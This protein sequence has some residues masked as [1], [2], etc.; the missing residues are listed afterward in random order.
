MTTKFYRAICEA[1]LAVSS[2]D[3]SSCYSISQNGNIQQCY[4]KT[5]YDGEYSREKNSFEEICS[6]SNAETLTPDICNSMKIRFTESANQFCLN[7]PIRAI[8]ASCASFY[9]SRSDFNP[10]SCLDVQDSAMKNAC[11]T[12]WAPK[13]TNGANLCKLIPNA[14]FGWITSADRKTCID[15]LIKE[16]TGINVN[17]VLRADASTEA[18]SNILSSFA[19]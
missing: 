17:N 13:T 15:N 10:L 18:T 1:H 3:L 16:K 6:M 14:F 19:A 8:K 12:Y 7:L 11:L 4:D 9:I 2:N 5:L